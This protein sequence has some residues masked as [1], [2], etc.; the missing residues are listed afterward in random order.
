[1]PRAHGAVD[2][3]VVVVTVYPGY[4]NLLICEILGRMVNN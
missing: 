4:T 3:S 1:M 2:C